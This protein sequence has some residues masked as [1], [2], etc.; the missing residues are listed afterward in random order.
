M[1]ILA[2]QIFTL[3]NFWIIS[4][5][6]SELGGEIISRKF[7]A[8]MKIIQKREKV[9]IYLAKFSTFSELMHPEWH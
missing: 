5:I 4:Q 7:Q 6:N 9:K 2:R 1:G 3:S 8:N